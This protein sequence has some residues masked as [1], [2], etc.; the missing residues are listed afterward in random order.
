MTSSWYSVQV[1]MFQRVPHPREFE[2]TP[3]QKLQI[4]E[5]LFKRGSTNPDWKFMRCF[6]RKTNKVYDQAFYGPRAL[7]FPEAENRKWIIMAPCGFD[8][9]V[10]RWTI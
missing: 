1:R 10:S 5:K 2:E 8:L 4:P 6:P 3:S 7:V 9:L